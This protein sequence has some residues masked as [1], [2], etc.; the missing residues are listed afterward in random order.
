MIII[1]DNTIKFANLLKI[2]II[3][4]LHVLGVNAKDFKT[5]SW[6]RDSNIDFTIEATETTKSR[7]NRVWSVGG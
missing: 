3:V 1:N 2:D 4:K 5:T 7:V 6:V